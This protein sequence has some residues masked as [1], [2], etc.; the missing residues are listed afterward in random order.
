ME[1]PPKAPTR[2]RAGPPFLRNACLT[3]TARHIVIPRQPRRCA[4][5]IGK[6]RLGLI[7][8][9]QGSWRQLCGR[10]QAATAS[11]IRIAHISTVA[12]TRN[13][14]QRAGMTK[15]N[16]TSITGFIIITCWRRLLRHRWK[17][18]RRREER[19]RIH[20]RQ[21]MQGPLWLYCTEDHLYHR[22]IYT[23]WSSTCCHRAP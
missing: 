5:P 18:P 3:G 17:E 20:P 1:T 8:F 22:N 19:S 16:T 21:G 10:Y 9:N 2:Q 6:D 14:Y 15:R 7:L 23:L 11:G 12:S 4:G 13:D